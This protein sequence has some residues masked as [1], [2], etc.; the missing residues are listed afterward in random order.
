MI[1]FENVAWQILESTIRRSVNSRKSNMVGQISWKSNS[2]IP[3]WI[4]KVF[5][6]ESEVI[7]WNFGV[8]QITVQYNGSC[9]WKVNYSV[10]N[11]SFEFDMADLRIQHDWSDFWETNNSIPNWV[12][13]GFSWS[14]I[15]SEK[16]TVTE[17]H[18]MYRYSLDR[19]LICLTLWNYFQSICE[20]NH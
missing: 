3:D 2:S 7:F 8:L 16:Q 18:Q 9:F 14:R 17:T 20:L 15:W 4:F 11:L 10:L 1:Y 12:S 6:Y 5:N 19:Y 13:Y